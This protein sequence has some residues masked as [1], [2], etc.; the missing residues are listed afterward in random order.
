MKYY[1]KKST[2]E[3]LVHAEEIIVTVS[4]DESLRSRL[5]KVGYSDTKF[6]QVYELLDVASRLETNQRVQLGKQVAATTELI[7]RTQSMRLKFVSDR[8]ITRFILKSDIS[9]TEELRL[10]IRTKKGREALIRQMTHFYEEVVNHEALIDELTSEFNLTSGLFKRRLEDVNRM[11]QA[12]QVQQYQMGK[13]RVATQERREAMRLLDDWMSRFIGIA[14]QVFRD[15]KE[16][17]YKLDIYSRSRSRNL[18]VPRG[19]PGS[20]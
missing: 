13:A 11:A 5:A 10:H 2:P 12:M 14:R 9:L 17:L 1:G 6:D 4:K 7:A 15:E 19:L 8:K 3:R 18:G 16:K 20:E